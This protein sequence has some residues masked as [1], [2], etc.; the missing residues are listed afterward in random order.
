VVNRDNYENSK[1]PVVPGE[2]F[3]VSAWLDASTAG[4]DVAF[5]CYYT[6]ASGNALASNSWK[7]SSVATK[8][9]SWGFVASS[10]VVPTGAAF[11]QAWFQI[12]G[13]Q[14]AT[15]K[16]TAR[17]SRFRISRSQAGATVGAPT[18]TMVG[19]TEAGLVASY[20]AYGNAA[21]NAIL[22]GDTGLA[23]RMRL[24]A[25][26][27]LS[28]VGGL[29]SG[30]LTYDSNGNR[31]GGS[32]V[33][34]N[35]KGIVGFDANGA[36]TVT[37]D[38]TSGNVSITGTVTAT[39]GA[40]GNMRL[41]SGG[42]TAGGYTS[43]A[44]PTGKNSDGTYV[45]GCYYGQEGILL[46]NQNNN[47]YFQVI[48]NGDVYAPGFALVGGQLTLTN[49]I[50]VNPKVQSGFSGSITSTT[51]SFYWTV[52]HQNTH[53]YG[54]SYNAVPANGSGNYSYNWSVSTS[55]VCIASLGGNPT[56]SQISLYA[57][58][59]G[60]TGEFDFYLT[61]VITDLNTN[62]SKTISQVTTMNFT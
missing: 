42:L 57:N 10:H 18:G 34:M 28:G 59:Q 58:S 46:G 55:S 40:I 27:I 1:F 44:W 51:N 38:A 17:G 23:Q 45:T 21:N 19:G 56:G 53:A 13:N 7:G 26:N 33:A 62:I 41:S 54:G 43:Y 11:G 14:A 6:D 52:S 32:G 35:Q 39:A 50:I 2:T 61:C 24:N 4:Y 31:T 48:S 16:G 15:D 22:N 30:T 37:I 47:K 60:G 49:T 3:F 29:V 20:A 9:T 36:A 8:G 5:G 25:A 12:G